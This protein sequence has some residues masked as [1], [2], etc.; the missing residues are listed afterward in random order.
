[1][2]VEAFLIPGSLAE[3]QG[4]LRALGAR[5]TPVAGA[6]SHLF[7]RGERPVTLVDLSRTG[8]SGIAARGDVFVIGATTPVAELRD[9][10]APGWVLD[11]VAACFVNQQIRNQSTLGGNVARVFPWSDFAVA[12]LALDATMEIAGAPDRRMRA[13]DYFQGQPARHFVPGDLLVRIEVP[14]LGAGVG[15]GYRKERRTAADYSLCTVAA[16]VEIGGGVV[17]A[18]RVALGAAVAMPQRLAGVETRLIGARPAPAALGA[19]VEEGMGGMTFVRAAG[20]S[21]EYTAHLAR[22]AVC[23]AIGDAVREAGGAP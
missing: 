6:T 20:F 23:D 11:R 1:M 22:V 15:F 21:A 3:A 13:D 7:L 8:I 19:A 14:C 12:M 16:R 4:Q 2:K 9:F 17:R 5:G 18:A 10:T